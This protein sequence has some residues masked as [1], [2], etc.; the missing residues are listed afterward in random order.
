MVVSCILSSSQ[1][2]NDNE[3]KRNLSQILEGSR[4]ISC[5]TYVASR[6]TAL[7]ETASQGNSENSQCNFNNSSENEEGDGEN[8][9]AI[10]G[11]GCS[12]PGSVASEILHSEHGHSSSC[13]DS[14]GS[15]NED[16]VVE[17]NVTYPPPVDNYSN[18]G[19]RQH[20]PPLPLIHS[21]NP[22]V[23]CDCIT[24]HALIQSSVIPNGM[25]ARPMQLA[26]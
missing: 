3:L 8:I 10:E 15:E 16:D 14:D 6:L 18:R 25:S 19:S 9:D 26:G 20:H 1:L 7:I 23:V 11:G 2:D 5:L 22:T 4:D 12:S 17:G 13:S 21:C 24:V